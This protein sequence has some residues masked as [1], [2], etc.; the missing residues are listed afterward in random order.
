MHTDLI[1][2]GDGQH[3]QVGPNP[4]DYV[5]RYVLNQPAQSYVPPAE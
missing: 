1:T 5:L 3:T 2:D 4:L